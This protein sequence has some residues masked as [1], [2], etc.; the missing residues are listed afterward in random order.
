MSTPTEQS[1]A[2]AHG[3]TLATKLLLLSLALAW[4]QFLWFLHYSWSSAS[5]Y[6]YGWLVPPLTALLLWPRL[7][8]GTRRNASSN[9]PGSL[10]SAIIF[11]G[12]LVFVMARLLIEVNPFWRLPL[13][14]GATTLI[15]SS[16]AT[17]YRL[18]GAKT[19]ASSLFP[20]LFSL[21]MVPWP[22]LVEKR[23][24]NSLTT[25]VTHVSVESLQILGNPAEQMGNLI[26]IGSTVVGVEEACSGIKSL[27]ALSMMALFVG[28][29][30]G[31]KVSGRILLVAAAVLL[32]ILFN[33]ARSL[34]LS[35]LVL[36][37]GQNLF[38]KWHDT[39]GYIALGLGLGTLFLIGS[40][41]PSSIQKPDGASNEVS[42]PMPLRLSPSLAGISLAIALLPFFISEFW[43]QD[44]ENQSNEQVDWI[45]DL[46]AYA[47]PEITTDQQTIPPRVEEILGF[48]Y[49]HHL[50]LQD[51]NLKRP[52]ELWYYGF[53]GESKS[54]SL[55]AY[56]HTP[57]ICMSGL[58]AVM[59]DRMETL[60]VDLG[61]LVIPFQHFSFRLPNGEM[62]QVFWCL[63]DDLHQ[64]ATESIEGHPRLAQFSAFFERKR[65]LKRKIALLGIPSDD[66][67][68]ARQE[69]TRLVRSLFL[70]Q[71][72]GETFRYR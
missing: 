48:D 53:T 4:G 69:A 22:S 18:F 9:A 19:A 12:L 61:A 43:Y 56:S 31:L 52:A 30:W 55:Q 11:A 49:G 36:N 3:S 58:G 67:Q 65:S 46:D 27:Q 21:T 70:L 54:K 6:N 71:K 10:I 33:L 17:I 28:A 26:Q 5:S 15:A 66:P 39:V 45:V 47:S 29:F 57:S 62:S 35:L 44:E 20:L 23:V 40:K 42:K 37:G 41:L 63:W 13:W 14:L 24:V 25:L 32:T 68:L 1:S 60:S 64:G 51:A 59:E 38:D 7:Q 2:K 8:E 34:T 50:T 16:W 72:D